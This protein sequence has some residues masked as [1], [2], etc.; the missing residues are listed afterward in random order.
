[1]K[2]R[3]RLSLG[4]DEIEELP[5]RHLHHEFA[6]AGKLGEIACDEA[7]IADLGRD[8]AH[9]VVRARQELLEQAELADQFECRRMDGVA[10]E[11]AQEVLVLFQYDHV[12][13]GTRQKIAADQPGWPAARDHALGRKLVHVN[14]LIRADVRVANRWYRVAEQSQTQRADHARQSPQRHLVQRKTLRI[15]AG[16]ASPSTCSMVTSISARWSR[17]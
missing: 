1:M 8:L 11:V 15:R 7:L 5:L 16:T 2:G 12:D 17:C 13:A 9:L 14:E 10:T 4:R 6:T 3:K